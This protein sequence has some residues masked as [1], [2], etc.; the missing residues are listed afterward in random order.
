MQKHVMSA[1]FGAIVF[2]VLEQA[3]E[4]HLKETSPCL[5]QFFLFQIGG[6]GTVRRYD[7]SVA[8]WDRV[9]ATLDYF[10]TAEQRS[11]ICCELLRRADFDRRPEFRGFWARAVAERRVAELIASAAIAASMVSRP[12]PIDAQRPD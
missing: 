6:A 2:D 12:L 1:G 5:H 10:F 4:R 7:G 9:Q 3:G 8:Y 11:G